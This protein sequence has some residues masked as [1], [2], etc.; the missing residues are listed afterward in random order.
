MLFFRR[1][2]CTVRSVKRKI[3]NGLIVLLASAFLVVVSATPAVATEQAAAPPSKIIEP[4]LEPCLD[5]ILAPL[6]KDP[7]MP[8]VAVE[9]LRASLAAD[10]VKSKTS[11]QQQIFQCA[12]AVCESLTSGMDERAQTRA[13]AA[14]S[15]LLP[16]VSNGG[17][18]VKTSP[19]R[20]WDAG[21]NAEAIRQK[22]KDERNYAD[23]QAAGVSNFME[24]S[25][26]KAWVT[27]TTALR[28][29]VM[30]LYTKLVQLEAVDPSATATAIVFTAP[31][32]PPALPAPQQDP[33]VESND[34]NLLRN[35]NFEKGTAGW[36]LQNW[37]KDGRMAIDEQETHDGKRTLRVE[38]LEACHSFIRQLLRGEPH[39]RYRLS[40]YLKTKSVQPANGGRSGAVL[41]VGRMGIYTPLM[42]GTQSWTKVT[43]DFTT[44]D[45]PEF[46]VGPSV[47][48]DATFATGTAWFSELTLTK[49]DGNER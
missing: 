26:Y 19:L 1:D 45:D 34:G 42:D 48:L 41:E 10:V 49:L 20:G 3:F 12:M 43:V 36:D 14:A 22:Q 29:N 24:S 7:P 8:R 4:L 17:S 15:G 23:R 40:C 38:N 9:K 44:G 39:T 30:N 2:F 16:S 32:A 47:G 31:T 28:E 33:G 5:A 21:A 13:A 27:R 11:S 18:I 25:A 35:A 6:E 37:G 46:R